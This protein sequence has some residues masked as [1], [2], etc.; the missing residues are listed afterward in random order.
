MGLST[1]EDMGLAQA[2]ENRLHRERGKQDAEHPHDHFPRSHADQLMD[3][4]GEQEQHQ[5][6]RHHRKDGGDDRAEQLVIALGAGGEHD[7]GGHGAW[8][9]EQRRGEREHRDLG[10]RLGFALGLLALLDREHGRLG[11]LGQRHL[12]GDGEQ[13]D[14]ARGLQRGERDAELSQHRA[15]RTGRTAR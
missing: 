13:D 6:D 9:G 5:S 1:T 15:R 2:V 11:L 10:M 8:A 14:A 4:L 12:H 7:S 3:L